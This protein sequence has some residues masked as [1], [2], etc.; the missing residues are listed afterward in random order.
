MNSKHITNGISR[1]FGRFAA[2]AH[3]PALQGAINRAYVRLMK[4]DM[5]E[6]EAP[7][8]YP[9]L[10]ALFTRALKTPRPL[11]GDQNTLLAPCDALAT[12][13]GKVEEGVLFQIKGM[14]YKL[15]D[16]LP[17]LPQSELAPLTNGDY[18]NLYLSPRDYHRYH[19]PTALTLT[20]LTHIPGR[21][22]PVNIPFLKKKANLFVENERVVL[23]GT[24]LKGRTWMLIF[25]GALNVGKMR[26]VHLAGFE[27]NV[28]ADAP[29]SYPLNVR[30]D[31]GDLLGWFEMG[32]T[33]VLITPEGAAQFELQ[34]GDRSVYGGKIGWLKP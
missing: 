30:V 13:C 1:A 8:S 31:R 18:V 17:H 23:E 14:A 24:D 11:A 15:A 22:W 34:E 12:Q 19:T 27:S 6:F 29:T 3:A 25:V 21:L 7:E 2:K 32:S 33:V 16:L 9:T 26:F 28:K 4:L 10:T 20:R 5:G